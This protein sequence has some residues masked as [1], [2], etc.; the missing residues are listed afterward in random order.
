MFD[1]FKTLF[2]TQKVKPTTYNEL[3][4]VYI[5]IIKHITTN[6]I[7]IS[8]QVSTNKEGRRKQYDYT[9][10]SK[11]IELHLN[12]NTTQTNLQVMASIE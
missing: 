12:L 1:A 8:K 4:K 5:G 7:I 3:I 10:N 6:D 2:R 9:L 11:L